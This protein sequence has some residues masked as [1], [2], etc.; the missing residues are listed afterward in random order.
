MNNKITF[1]LF[2]ILLSLN[3]IIS[4]RPQATFTF[5]L[6]QDIFKKYYNECNNVIDTMNPKNNSRKTVSKFPFLL[7]HVGLTLNDLPDEIEC[8]SLTDND[9]TYYVIVTVRVDNFYNND[10]ILLL[11]F[12]DLNTFS[13]GGCATKECEKPLFDLVKI[14]EGF[15]NQ[16]ISN[17]QRN[18]KPDAIRYK[19]DEHYK[20]KYK[21]FFIVFVIFIIYAIIKLIVG[22]IR[23]IYIPKG[24]DI[25]VKKLSF[26]QKKNFL[27]GDKN[28][29]SPI[30]PDEKNELIEK[31]EN[32]VDDY[33]ALDN[34][35]SD[36]TSDF[37]LYLRIVRFLDLLNDI[38]LLTKNKNRY[39]NDNGLEVINFLRTI[40]LYFYIFSNSFTTLI[41]FPSKDKLNKAFFSSNLLF[42]Y[43]FSTHSITCWIFL[44]A[45]YT[46]YKLMK[47]IKIQMHDNNN[48]KR[49]NICNTNLLIVYGK[50][51]LLF[52]P[53]ICV[54]FFCFYTFYYDI[55]KFV[56]LFSAKTT[57]KYVVERI[58]NQNNAI[59]CNNQ[60]SVFFST[61]KND[62]QNFNTCFDFT[63]IYINI[64][65]CVFCFLITVYIILTFK[66]E[67]IEIFFML[68]YSIFCFGLIFTVR[69]EKMNTKDED[70]NNEDN[71]DKII[72]SYYHFKGQEYLHKIAY[73]TLGVYHLGFILGILCFNYDNIKT[74]LKNKNKADKLENNNSSIEL[75]SIGKEGTLND[76]FPFS[77]SQSHNSSIEYIIETEKPY[78]PL[79]FF[80]GI[81]IRLKKI[82]YGFKILIIIICL[83]IQIF[84]SFF[85]IIYAKSEKKDEKKILEMELDDVLKG[86]FLFEKHIFLILFFI[87]SLI[88][89]TIPKKGLF[90]KLIRAKLVTAISRVG[91]SIICLSYIINNFTFCGFLIKIKFDIPNFIIISIGNFLVI[92]IVCILI[93]II[94]ELPI[95][96]VIKK[97]LRLNKKEKEI[98]FKKKEKEIYNQK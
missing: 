91:F 55:L 79:S 24:Y 70:E 38:M 15:N 36:Y 42:F 21:T 43:R 26:E 59:T 39:Y 86:Y 46:A 63:F 75:K 5:D 52:I 35:I 8:K 76:S 3:F 10:D 66:K 72:Y 37:P 18:E 19:E 80:N 30:I 2:I 73:L 23:F 74:E 27:F 7:E 14:F 1:I 31:N 77:T 51:I 29:K 98:P 88:L 53:K 93:N 96:M 34:T 47:F 25:Y 67:I 6:F 64:F 56:D 44:E 82:K 68:F 17:K 81:L 33:K 11:K 97:L 87:I 54:F 4:E 49:N 22:A 28:G 89:I 71:K 12:L 60:T 90:K 62:T 50:F 9:T 32:I 20:K 40:V 45:S 41:D 16:N 78:Y 61:F 94:V 57:F 48:K 83:A 13:V 85:F 92:F 84:L 65:F 95:R 69:D 58:I